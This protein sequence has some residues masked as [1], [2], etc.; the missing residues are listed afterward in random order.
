MILQW[1]ILVTIHLS[2]PRECVTPK[3]N[4]IVNCGLWV[5]MIWPSRFI[6]CNKCTTLTGDVDNVRGY[7]CVRARNTWEISVPSRQ[8]YCEPKTA[9]KNKIKSILKICKLVLSHYQWLLVRKVDTKRPISLT[10][11][12]HTQSL[13]LLFDLETYE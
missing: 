8:F 5:I 4:S 12:Y 1:G 2:E 3:V 9:P 6:S 11:Q 7:A 10:S 13:N